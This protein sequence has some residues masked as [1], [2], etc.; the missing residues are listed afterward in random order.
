MVLKMSDQT[1]KII[2]I[3][4]KLTNISE[5]VKNDLNS[6]WE[7]VGELEDKVLSLE[8]DLKDANAKIDMLERTK[9]DNK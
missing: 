7:R 3:I 2:E 5:H 8:T 9:A 6:L 1:N 4:E